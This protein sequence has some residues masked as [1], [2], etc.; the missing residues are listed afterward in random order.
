VGAAGG[1]GGAADE[2]AVEAKGEGM[3]GEES[4]D[5]AQ[6]GGGVE[7]CYMAESTSGLRMEEE[8]GRRRSRR[9][10]RSRGGG[11]GRSNV[12]SHLLQRQLC[13]QIAP[14]CCLLL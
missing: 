13:F 4:G 2:V 8:N 6:I 1:A 14:D 12:N 7:V 11:R 5:G 9:R 10:R 3:E